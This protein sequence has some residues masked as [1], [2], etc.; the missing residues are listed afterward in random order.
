MVLTLMGRKTTIKLSQSCISKVYGREEDNRKMN[1]TIGQRI[2]QSDNLH[3]THEE[4]QT[5]IKHRVGECNNPTLLYYGG[6]GGFG[7]E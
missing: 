4:S 6:W 2:G 7:H 1:R 5:T 3:M